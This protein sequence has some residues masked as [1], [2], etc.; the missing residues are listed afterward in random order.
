MGETRGHDVH[1]EPRLDA[2]LC[3]ELDSRFAAAEAASRVEVG[4]E[5]EPCEVVTQPG[6]QGAAPVRNGRTVEHHS[7]FC[8]TCSTGTGSNSGTRRTKRAQMNAYSA[9]SASMIPNCRYTGA[10]L[11]PSGVMYPIATRIPTVAMI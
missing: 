1:Q 3:D 8:S 2:F 6:E 9:V 4:L 7:A 11:V 5:L 10:A